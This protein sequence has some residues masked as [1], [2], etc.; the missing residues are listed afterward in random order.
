MDDLGAR[1]AKVRIL[2]IMTEAFADSSGPK[3]QSGTG[4]ADTSVKPESLVEWKGND[5]Y[6][7]VRRIGEG[8]MG[9]V[10][11]AF[12]RERG[13][14]VAVKSLLHF[15]PAA[16]YRF[17]QEFRTLTDVHHRNL[18]RLY[19]LVVTEDEA[20]FFTMEAV[21]GADFLTYV[22]KP[23]PHREGRTP[24]SLRPF[25]HLPP[26]MPPPPARLSCAY[27]PRSA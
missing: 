7:C 12:D 26:D 6:R 13:Q 11:E 5:R 14:P 18:V 9:V 4:T 27:E 19:E 23:G 25:A 20:V 10:Y 21:G 16:L 17:K 24:S 8:G 22:Q 2:G 15:S 1:A 3:D